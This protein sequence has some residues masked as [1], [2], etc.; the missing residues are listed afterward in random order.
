MV[1][2]GVGVVLEAVMGLGMGVGV[3]A[4]MGLGLGVVMGVI[5]SL[6][7]EPSLLG[8]PMWTED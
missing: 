6:A 2:L 8:F 4:V 1:G 3:G 7:S 5:S